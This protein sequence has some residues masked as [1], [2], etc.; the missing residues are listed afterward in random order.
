M[1][2]SRSFALLALAGLVTTLLVAISPFDAGAQPTSFVEL[3]N[4]NYNITYDGSGS[5][6][7][8]STSTVNT[9]ALFG[10]GTS[11]TAP[12]VTPL[13]PAYVATTN[14]ITAHDFIVDPLASDATHA[15]AP[16]NS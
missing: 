7:W 13:P 3:D 10:G 4:P 2:R 9:G 11:L 12:N 16:A 8:G 5:Y 1:G 6:D 14:T 15:G